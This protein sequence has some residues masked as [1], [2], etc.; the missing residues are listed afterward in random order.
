MNL[1][2]PHWNT[3]RDQPFVHGDDSPWPV[4]NLSPKH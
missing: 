3:F 1:M 2:N 4:Q